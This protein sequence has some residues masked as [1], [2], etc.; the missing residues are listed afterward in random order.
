MNART[1]VKLI[2]CLLIFSAVTGFAKERAGKKA[3]PAAKSGIETPALDE[4]W[5]IKFG[6]TQEEAKAVLLAKPGA[7]LSEKLTNDEVLFVT[8]LSFSGREAKSV[9]LYFI[10]G[11]LHTAQ[12]FFK[13]SMSKDVFAYFDSVKADLDARY[14]P[15][16]SVE[17]SY[18]YPTTENDEYASRE[19]AARVGK[20]KFNA[21]WEFPVSG[22]LSN[23]IAL[24][25]GETLS[26]SITYSDGA[27]FKKYE[28]ALQAAS[29]KDL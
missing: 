18:Q 27:L 28:A 23:S 29:R 5:G 3:A 20:A 14:F 21:K 11:Q 15:A 26:I 25:L 13:S 10:E 1:V 8:G 24:D 7:R 2:V 16:T 22:A 9:R 6:A 19:L 4:F 12:V 17:R